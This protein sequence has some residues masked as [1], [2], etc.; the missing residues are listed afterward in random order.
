[1]GM[2]ISLVAAKT[3]APEFRDAFA[4]AWPQYEIVNSAEKLRNASALWKWKKANE[5]FVSAADST[6]DNPA[7][8]VFL[9]W[10]DGPWATMLDP[11]YGP[12]CDE[13]G[14]KKLSKRLG[15][16][17]SFVIETTS[18][19]AFFWCFQEGKLRRQ[20]INAD[21]DVS[22]KGKPM[23]EE[24]GID[25][26]EYYDEESE[27]LWTAFGLSPYT[28][29]PTSVGCQAICVVDRTDYEDD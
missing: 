5:K 12:A 6:P 21:T 25:I 13:K 2:H 16:V 10:Q 3:S 14:L 19:C 26:S 29:M 23:P 20:I 11:D 7:K 1:M 24:A 8:D 9:F 22:T 28:K 15:T 18:G 4:L 27:A 17:L